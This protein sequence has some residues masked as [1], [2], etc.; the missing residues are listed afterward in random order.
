[1]ITIWCTQL[2]K[3]SFCLLQGVIRS[4]RIH[5]HTLIFASFFDFAC[6]RYF[7]SIVPW[8]FIEVPV[9]TWEKFRFRIRLQT[10]FCTV[11]PI[12]C[13]K[14]CLSNVRSSIVWRKIYISNLVLVFI[15][16]ILCLIRIKIRF[17]NRIRNRDAFRLR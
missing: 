3:Q 2:K 15:Y 1:L 17:R 13:T 4:R 7:F 16:F 10:I 8:W 5:T 12:N 11:L 6:V 14:S 9:Q